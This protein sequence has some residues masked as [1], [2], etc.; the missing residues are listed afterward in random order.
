MTC[1]GVGAALGANVGR[2]VG[3]SDG[4][5]V[6]AGLG[7]GVGFFVGLFVGYRV[8]ANVEHLPRPSIVLNGAVPHGFDAP[9]HTLEPLHWQNKIKKYLQQGGGQDKM[10]PK[11]MRRAIAQQ[12]HT[13][14]RAQ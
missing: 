13:E 3:L 10:Q 9:V 2:G 4:K 7:K 12:T 1:V 5:S 14:K 6:G 8:G 11:R